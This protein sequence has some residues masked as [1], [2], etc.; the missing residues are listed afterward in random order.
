MIY[1]ESKK[2]KEINIP[3]TFPK[4]SSCNQ[5]NLK[6]EL[7]RNDKPILDCEEKA[8][9]QLKSSS[10]WT[11]PNKLFIP[12]LQEKGNGTNFITVNFTGTGC[13]RQN[14]NNFEPVLGTEV[15]KLLKSQTYHWIT[16]FKQISDL[17]AEFL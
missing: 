10:F 11:Q 2:L 4:I 7:K 12:Q 1:K 8:I 9:P 5:Y 3:I 15:L 6:A 14:E 13:G 17:C 16:N